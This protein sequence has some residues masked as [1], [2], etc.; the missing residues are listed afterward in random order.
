V[1]TDVVAT[2]H[3]LMELDVQQAQ[4][5]QS[6]VHASLTQRFSSGA[7]LPSALTGQLDYHTFRPRTR[8]D[9][10]AF[11]QR[12]AI[13]VTDGAAALEVTATKL[14]LAKADAA[15]KPA[16]AAASAA[17]AALVTQYDSQQARVLDMV[18][19]VDAQTGGSISKDTPPSA[20][21][22]VMAAVSAAAVASNADPS[23]IAT[24]IDKLSRMDNIVGQEATVPGG[25]THL[26][27]A[28]EAFA[29]SF[30]Q[31]IADEADRAAER[32]RDEQKQHDANLDD[33][34][35]AE[36]KSQGSQQ[37]EAHAQQWAAEAVA[38]FEAA[39]QLSAQS[40]AQFDARLNKTQA[41]AS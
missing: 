24:T 6:K 9:A 19:V 26:N 40:A 28:V 16:D 13:D 21:D 17:V 23:T 34:R 32:Q 38:Q 18:Q 35:R 1:P 4:A 22:R 25:S 31:Y 36:E 7:Q 2:Q 27:R 10:D 33:D 30:S 8:A 41:R 39:A 11:A 3:Q 29:A 5:R 12:M 14:Q 15:L 20:P 37:V